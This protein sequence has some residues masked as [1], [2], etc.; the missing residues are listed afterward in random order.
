MLDSTGKLLYEKGTIGVDH[1]TFISRCEFAPPTKT[2]KSNV[3]KLL[4][5]ASRPTAHFRFEFGA[6]GDIF[7]NKEPR[8]YLTGS[9]GIIGQICLIPLKPFSDIAVREQQRN[10][11]GFYQEAPEETLL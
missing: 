10:S 6:C 7:Q 1:M 3:F 11:A 2:A 4:P 8:L 9:L 5:R